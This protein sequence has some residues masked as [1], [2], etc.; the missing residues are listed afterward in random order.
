MRFRRRSRSPSHFPEIKGTTLE[1]SPVSIPRDLPA[2]WNLLVVSF[3]EGQDALADHWVS[4]ARRIAE[5]S[6]GRLAALELPVLGRSPRML[7]PIIRD[8][9]DAQMDDDDERA[10]TMPI[11][12][13]RKAFSRRLG[14]RSDDSVDVFLVAQDGR[15][16]W[17]GAGA[18]VP[19]LV[20][21]LERA[22]G[23]TLTTRAAT[24][25]PPTPVDGGQW[26]VDSEQ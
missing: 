17:R 8:T 5:S 13:D 18:L 19:D 3:H 6:G 11:H 4:L 22:V 24:A 20:A 14:L 21:G 16:R 1:G 10:R 7:R 12:A 25:G 23:E 15:I 26:T 2:E 9:L